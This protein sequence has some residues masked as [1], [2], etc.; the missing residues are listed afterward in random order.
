MK[1]KIRQNVFK[2]FDTCCQITS[3]KIFATYFIV[4]FWVGHNFHHS[5]LIFYL[6]SN[7][8]FSALSSS[9]TLYCRN[10][11]Y[12]NF[13]KSVLT[14]NKTWIWLDVILWFLLLDLSAMRDSIIPFLTLDCLCLYSPL[15]FCGCS[16]FRGSGP[17]V[18][19]GRL[20]RWPWACGLEDEP[21]ISAL[22]SQGCVLRLLAH[23]FSNGV[24]AVFSV[25]G[26]LWSPVLW[27]GRM[28]WFQVGFLMLGTL[29][30]CFSLGPQTWEMLVRHFSISW[31]T[32]YNVLLS[33]VREVL[34]DFCI[35]V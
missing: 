4:L 28:S 24:W 17:P 10:I 26:V 25:W 19:E 20:Q 2:V 32:G 8:K 12:S 9:V 31:N 16:Q 21:G 33:Q 1:L 15:N 23:S 30:C 11:C 7:G 29:L 6:S 14:R 34:S 3:R 22:H 18:W 27:I 13:L 5:S 35:F